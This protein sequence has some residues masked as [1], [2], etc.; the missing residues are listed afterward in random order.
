MQEALIPAYRAA[1]FC[2]LA[3]LALPAGSVAL[4][5]I[6]V[7]SAL[8]E[9]LDARI[10][11]T[12]AEGQ[13]LDSMCFS[14]VR[15][16]EPGIPM[17]TEGELSVE[18]RAGAPV[19]RVRTSVPVLEPA[20]SLRVR[21]LCAT[22]IVEAQRQYIVLLDPR[23]GSGVAPSPP[24]IAATL[25]AR[26][27]DT[28][29]AIA[30]KA[31]RGRVAR[32]QYL[33]AIRSLNPSL[34]TLGARD[35]IPEGA[36]VDLPDLRTYTSIALAAP[37]LPSA[38]M[39]LAPREPAAPKLPVE[40]KSPPKPLAVAASAAAA[41]AP[42]AAPAVRPASKPRSKPSSSAAP[43]SGFVLKLSSSEVDLS[44]SRQIDDRMRAQLRERLMVLDNDDQV[45]V[46]LSMRNSL[47]QLEARVAELQLKLA[48]MPASL[49]A[50]GESPPSEKPPVAET[51]AP[52]PPPAAKPIEPPAPAAKPIEPSAP[53]V[54]PQEP[55]PIAK[56]PVMQPEPAQP[57]LAAAPPGEPAASPPEAS[58]PK[59]PVAPIASPRPTAKP[60][61]A[62]ADEGGLSPW[63]WAIVAI[64]VMLAAL[65]ALRVW[66][67]RQEDASQDSGWATDTLEPE[68]SPQ[69]TLEDDIFAEEP[70]EVAPEI[71]HE[72][73]PESR[74]E[75][76]QEISSD[77]EL[78]TRLPQNSGELRRRYIEE[79][80]PEIVNRTVMLDDPNSVVKGARLFYEDGA[81]P[82]AVELLQ[83]SIEETPGEVKTWLALFEIFRLERLTSEFAT[84]ARR[85]QERHGTSEYWAKVQY[86]GREIDPGNPLY[87][88][89]SLNT[90]ETIGPSAARRLAAA[91][92]D[93]IAENWLN[94]PMDF[95]NEVLANELRNALM[96]D[97]NL[98]EQDL[99]PNPMPALRNIEMF[100]VA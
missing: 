7:R 8:G 24:V 64:L 80:F 55:A 95:E 4:G 44:R 81:L 6:E 52:T 23:P 2:A 77:A 48:Q 28:L 66:R 49:A 51:P 58:A 39:E 29:E 38:A 19:L 16:T 73:H 61:P 60:R 1:L 3:V 79:R 90:L 88:D 10:A 62:V 86:F 14:L 41:Q 20:V 78:E 15:E 98:T 46:V 63:L 74:H 87:K 17:L 85:F 57:S 18:Q 26:A 34:A 83:F 42:A 11:V 13:G 54:K 82:R 68:E 93:P 27:G 30:A 33:A 84:L 89:A 69:S 76:R 47:K 65:L 35:P 91:S 12:P 96:V 72:A 45:A 94:A 50:R 59:S 40:R 21:A 32:R 9:R 70:I 97:A 75:A 56:A 37:A 99:I 36:A 71:E 25:N 43:S 5:E 67:R 100:T 31:V 22:D 92:F 53:E